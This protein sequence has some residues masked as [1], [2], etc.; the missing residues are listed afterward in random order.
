MGYTFADAVTAEQKSEICQLLARW[1]SRS[2]DERER[3]ETSASVKAP[4]GEVV[5]FSGVVPVVHSSRTEHLWV[6]ANVPPPPAA[7]P[8]K[9]GASSVGVGICRHEPG[10]NPWRGKAV[11]TDTCQH[12][13]SDGKD[14]S[15]QSQ[16]NQ[17]VGDTRGGAGVGAGAKYVV[18][19]DGS[20]LR[21]KRGKSS[22][23]EEN[24]EELID[25][26]SR[27][28]SEQGIVPSRAKTFRKHT[29]G[30]KGKPRRRGSTGRRGRGLSVQSQSDVLAGEGDK[31]TERPR[32]QSEPA[33]SATRGASDAPICQHRKLRPVAMEE[34]NQGTSDNPA[35]R[36]AADG[37]P[38]ATL[39]PS[40]PSKSKPSKAMKTY[41]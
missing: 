34:Q 27:M 7:A 28:A 33:P 37:S 26:E 1:G 2:G 14:L 24:E 6:P 3:A 29:A 15:S 41:W 5:Y 31:P 9:K 25:R 10:P 13:N 17:E 12:I 22:A 32:L 11:D 40:A 36:D 23:S 30:G 38:A 19:V 39:T 8:P 4:G 21:T 20:T 35:A 16:T 18:D